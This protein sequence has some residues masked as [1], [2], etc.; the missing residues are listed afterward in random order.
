MRATVVASQ[1]LID[2]YLTVAVAAAAAADRRHSRLRHV[3]RWREQRPEIDERL[4]GNDIQ[5]QPDFAS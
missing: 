3:E 5:L 4:D 1:Q 2:G